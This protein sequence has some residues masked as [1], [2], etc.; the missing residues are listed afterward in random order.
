VLVRTHAHAMLYDAGPRYSVES[1]AAQRVLLPLLRALG[2]L[3]LDRLVLSHRDSDHMGGAGSLLAGVRVDAVSSSLDAGQVQHDSPAVARWTRCESGQSWQWDGVR[4]DMLHPAASA[5]A[6][7]L[8]ANAMSCVL[9]VTDAAGTRMLL[10]GDI[11]AAQEQA[12]IERHGEALRAAVLFAP[13][14]GSRTSSSESLLKAVQ[15]RL[16]VVQAGWRNRF[17][18]P[19]PEVL[20]RY[21]Q[22]SVRIVRTDHCGAWSWRSD[23]GHG[24]CEREASRRF[25]HHRGGTPGESAAASD[26]AAAE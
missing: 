22:H 4:F 25:W 15:P 11:P 23:G 1:D 26:E 24:R 5:Y 2:D 10:T 18:H 13:H 21:A 7:R 9:A 14:H 8:P 20:A 12:I 3:R 6:K 16:A 19:A 17:G